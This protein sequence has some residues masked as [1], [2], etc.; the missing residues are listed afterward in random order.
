VA[1]LDVA[2]DYVLEYMR[3]E[4]L[5]EDTLVFKGGTALRK[6]V[7]GADGRFSVDLDFALRTDDPADVDRAFDLL[8][9]AEFAGVRITL[10]RRR[11][12]AALLRLET[13][14]GLVVEPAAVSVRPAGPWLPPRELAPQSFPLLDRRLEV[15]RGA[16]ASCGARP[17]ATSTTWTTWARCCRRMSRRRKRLNQAWA[18][19]TTQRR[20]RWRAG[21][22]GGGKGGAALALGGMCGT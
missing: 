8:D 3:R 7:F 10:E 16:P 19:S 2:Q 21:S 4:G 17:R 20:G 11:G 13:P 12:T 22:P 15:A 6:Y 9:G 1:L 14:L 18:T 5:F